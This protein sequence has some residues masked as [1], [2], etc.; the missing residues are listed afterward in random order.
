MEESQKPL[1]KPVHKG[2]IATIGAGVTGVIWFGGEL[3]KEAAGKSFGEWIGPTLFDPTLIVFTVIAGIS[4][5]I[6]SRTL[7]AE[8]KQFAFLVGLIIGQTAPMVL[9]FYLY[10]SAGMRALGFDFLVLVVGLRCRS[11]ATV[12]ER[13]DRLLAVARAVFGR[14]RS[15]RDGALLGA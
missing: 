6:A 11:P 3:A 10:G 7:K 1:G 15:V 14:H 13:R 2:L 9:V 5:W 12:A 4:W 8:L